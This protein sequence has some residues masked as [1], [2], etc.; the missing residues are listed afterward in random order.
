ML[1]AV[2]YNSSRFIGDFLRSLAPALVGAPACHVVII[3]NASVDRTPDIARAIAPWAIVIDAGANIGYAAGINVGLRSHPPRL[4]AYI[5]NPDTVPAP[6]SVKILVDAAGSRGDVGITVP[7]MLGPDGKLFR[8]LRREPTVRRALGEAIL[9]GTRAG[10]H[11]TLGEVVTDA[12][13]YRERRSAD[14]AT[15]AAM[16]VTRRTLDLVGLWDERFFL[17]SEETDYALR[18]RDRGL[19]LLFVPEAELQHIGGDLGTS[20]ALWSLMTVNRVR[21]YR[22]RHGRF[23]SALFWLA[24]TFG[25][26]GR[27]LAGKARSQAALRTLLSGG[28]GAPLGS[29]RGSPT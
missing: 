9:G 21:L 12:E 7:L 28:D 19:T 10:R 17:Y 23:R 6:G 25:E 14:W 15:G 24:V 16:F 2:T 13:L 27:A 1:I 20:D 18:A 22:K 4:G 5:L 11:E 26:A 29:R 3:D 8:S